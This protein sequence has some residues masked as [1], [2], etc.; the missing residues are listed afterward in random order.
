MR[1]LIYLF[2][3]LTLFFVACEKE[4]STSEDDSN[5]PIGNERPLTGEA[6]IIGIV[7]DQDGN[8]MPGVNVTCG[9]VTFTTNDKGRFQLDKAP[10]GEDIVVDFQLDG[11]MRTQKKLESVKGAERLVFAT[12]YPVGKISKV[13]ATEGGKAEHAGMSAEFPANAFVTADGQPFTGEAEVEITF[14]PTS[15]DRFAEIFPGDFEGLREDGTM[16]FVES[17]GFAD[18]NITADGQELKLADGKKA[19]LSYPV[20]D[21]QKGNAPA[22]I[23]LWYYDYGQGQWI[24]EGTAK[25]QGGKYVGEVSHF[26]PWN[27]DVPIE[28]SI[29]KGRVVNSEGSPI[30]SSLIY[31]KSITG[32]SATSYSDKDGNFNLRV[33]SNRQFEVQAFYISLISNKVQTSLLTS[34]STEDVG[35]LII[36]IKELE[37]GWEFDYR[38]ETDR[39]SSFHN[40]SCD[41]YLRVHRKYIGY[42]NY[43]VSLSRSETITNQIDEI[44]SFDYITE[45]GNNFLFVKPSYNINDNALLAVTD[46]V[47]YLSGKPVTI[48]KIVDRVSVNPNLV[49]IQLFDNGSSILFY[50]SDMVKRNDITSEPFTIPNYIDYATTQGVSST[51]SGTIYILLGQFQKHTMVV[52]HDFGESWNKV[53]L[54]ID[55]LSFDHR[56]FIDV[57]GRGQD[58]EFAYEQ[59]TELYDDNTMSLYSNGKIYLTRDSWTTYTVIADNCPSNTYGAWAFSENDIWISLGSGG[60]IQSIDGGK[61][62]INYKPM[63]AYPLTQMIKCREHEYKAVQMDGATI[64]YKTR[65]TDWL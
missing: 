20:A 14:V 48:E 28:T 51:A 31:S 18:I 32:W 49:D 38:P 55:Y 43:T 45:Y 40:L 42:H 7:Y 36:D 11:Y 15:T 37:G 54:P 57:T 52:S 10:E 46:D 19:T 65:Q 41:S 26:T 3:F 60:I 12:M 29:I 39:Q 21:A 56:M 1:K 13:S 17:Y 5:N 22:T 63:S 27:V 2:A 47:Y 58:K 50:R 44:I 64:R 16:T 4:E 62:W 8:E 61:T 9:A 30:S 35:D 25:L 6:T 24:E 34:N 59:Y 33:G 23:P 53:K